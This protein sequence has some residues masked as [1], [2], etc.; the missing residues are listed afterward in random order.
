MRRDNRSSAG[1]YEIVS[2]IARVKL[3]MHGFEVPIF[4]GAKRGLERADLLVVEA[5]NLA[6]AEE[7]ALLRAVRVPGRTRVPAGGP[8]RPDAPAA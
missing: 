8:V 7:P 4:E 1:G 2:V 5:C 3:D 6:R